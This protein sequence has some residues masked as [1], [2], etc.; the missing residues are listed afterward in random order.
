MKR[1]ALTVKSR[2]DGERID[3]FIA[4]QGG[5]SRGEARRALERGGVWIDD[6][7][8]KVA[9]REVH[10]GQT[11]QVV[12]EEGGRAEEAPIAPGTPRILFEDEAV[13]AVDKP[14]H[15]DAQCTLGNDRDDLLAWVTGHVGREIG[16]VHRLD[17][18]TSGVTVF[19]K[20]RHATA[21]LSAAF[22]EGTAHKRYLAAAFGELPQEGR[23]DLPLSP[24]PRRKGRFVAMESGKVT[25]A[26]RFRVLGR[27]G[28]LCA[29]ELFPETGRTHQIRAHLTALSAPIV[30]DGRYGGPKEFPELGA[31]ITR[32]M[33]H[34][35]SL[36]VPHPDGE[37]LE[38]RAPVPLDLG[39]VLHLANV[40]LTRL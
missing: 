34:A 19:G 17:R 36:L 27:N 15:M 38:L 29:V 2:D 12:L 25:A 24:D 20:T 6:K 32:V 4:R 14:A 33:L 13:I 9:S 40:E 30:G 39:L 22:R 37:V 7:R 23:I 31:K 21:V 35:R 11:I 8:V 16:L 3:R 18:E 1:L 26:T 5:V 28:K 10:D